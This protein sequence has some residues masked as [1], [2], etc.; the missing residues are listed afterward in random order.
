[1]N[2]ISEFRVAGSSMRTD[3]LMHQHVLVL[4]ARV[5]HSDAVLAEM[6]LRS[7]RKLFIFIIKKYISRIKVS[8]KMLNFNF[9]KNFTGR[10]S[11]EG[12][13]LGC[14]LEAVLSLDEYIYKQAMGNK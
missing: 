9:E 8:K 2:E 12:V 13:L 7:P 14:R 4:D 3:M 5:I 6:S 1:M 11:H 10:T